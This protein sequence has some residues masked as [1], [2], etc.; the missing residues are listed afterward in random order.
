[1]NWIDV[2]EKLPIIGQKVKF[3]IHGCEMEGRF[4]GQGTGMGMG[5]YSECDNKLKPVFRSDNVITMEATQ[6]MPLNEE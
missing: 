2:K 3:K 6:W 1:M 4:D 5:F